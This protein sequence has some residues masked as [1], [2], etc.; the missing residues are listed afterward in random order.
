LLS[1]FY[2]WCSRIYWGSQPVEMVDE[3]VW[4]ALGLLTAVIIVSAVFRWMSAWAL[5]PAM[6]LGIFA[7]VIVSFAPIKHA[8]KFTECSW[9]D[10]IAYVN[11][12]KFHMVITRCRTRNTL[13]SE[14]SDWEMRT[15]RIN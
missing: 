12:Q 11:D 6:V 14:W 3:I 5:A 9:S 13:D 2:E 10:Q 15:G 1:A 7:A 8:Q 4:L